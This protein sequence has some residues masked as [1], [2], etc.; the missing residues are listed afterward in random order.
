MQTR[1]G[2]AGQGR[3]TSTSPLD[4]NDT[5]GTRNKLEP[6]FSRAGMGNV[7]W[8]NA[9]R[10]AAGFWIGNWRGR[11][12][13]TRDGEE[14]TEVSQGT[15]RARWSSRCESRLLQWSIFINYLLL[16]RSTLLAETA[17]FPC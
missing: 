16:H 1:Q 6:G 13:G 8:K 17:L 9:G 7:A 3:A 2:T 14:K 5:T 10:W 15:Y 12:T 4:R 11:A